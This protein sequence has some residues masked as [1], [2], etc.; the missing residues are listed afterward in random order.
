MVP[1]RRFA[2]QRI[3]LHSARTDAPADAFVDAVS[4]AIA[5]A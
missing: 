2:T 5:I 3:F 4:V 1:Q